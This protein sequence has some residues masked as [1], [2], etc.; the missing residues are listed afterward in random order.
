MDRTN[1]EVRLW[2]LYTLTTSYDSYT[3]QHAKLLTHLR[4][5]RHNLVHDGRF[6]VRISRPHDGAHK[7]GR[8]TV[9]FVHV[10]LRITYLFF[11]I[12]IY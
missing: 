2:R 9:A 11:F 3:L 8:E 6:K 10:D 7:L 5:I 4:Y 12:T 1:F